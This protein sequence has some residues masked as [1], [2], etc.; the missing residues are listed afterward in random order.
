[1]NR[2]INRVLLSALLVI[3]E[4]APRTPAV[5]GGRRGVGGIDESDAC[6]LESVLIG[7]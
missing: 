6:A 5:A 7:K 2:K 4:G 1:M 3:L